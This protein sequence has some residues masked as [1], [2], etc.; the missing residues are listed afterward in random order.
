ML[1]HVNHATASSCTAQH[2]SALH[3]IFTVLVQCSAALHC[4]VP[5][6]AVPVHRSPV[7]TRAMA[8]MHALLTFA[9]S[10]AVQWLSTGLVAPKSPVRIR[11][12]LRAAS[13]YSPWDPCAKSPVLNHCTAVLV[14]GAAPALYC[15]GKAALVPYCA[16]LYC[17]CT[18]LCCSALYCTVCCTA[19]CHTCTV[20][21]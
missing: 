9:C 3:C 12:L 6:C 19:L 4:T 2:Y 8:C 17:T 20:L 10:I 21:W 1:N 5:C 13:Y 18:V 7:D 15:R 14:W 11:S 16:A